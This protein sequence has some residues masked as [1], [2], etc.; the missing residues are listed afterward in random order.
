MTK[1]VAAELV[2]F[3]VKLTIAESIKVGPTAAVPLYTNTA[4]PPR[5]DETVLLT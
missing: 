4:T 3:T 2:A 5:E 1:A